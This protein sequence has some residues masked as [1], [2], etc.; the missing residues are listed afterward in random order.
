VTDTEVARL[1]RRVERERAAR[2]E[3]EAIA[4]RSTRELWDRQQELVLLEA[5]AGAANAADS[6][7]DALRLVLAMV[8]KHLRW[9]IGQAWV[10]EKEQG[11]LRLAPVSHAV[12]ESKYQPFLAASA[13]AEFRPGE[14][15]PGR[16]LANSEPLLLPDV[17]T[18]NNF[19]R[20][21][22]ALETG[23][24]GAVAFPV[25]L[26]D[27]TVAVL[28][29][30][31]DTVID[32]MPALLR[33]L[34]HVGVQLAR[35]FERAETSERL[36]HDAL[37]D[38]LT[39]LPNRALFA[40]R[41]TQAIAASRRA[42]GSA[43][44]ALMDLDR[45]KEVNDTLGHLQGDQL[46][47]EVGT[48]LAHVL[49]AQDTIA[50]L[51]GDEFGIVLSDV[52]D[53]ADVLSVAD[54]VRS[55]LLPPV[56]LEG[57]MVQVDASVGL[58]LYPEHGDEVETLLRRADIA[59]YE[60]KRHHFG[61]Q[62][63]RSDLDPHSTERLGMAAALRQAIDS[64][65]LTLHYQP[66]VAIRGASVVTGV[67]ALLRW[68]QPDRGPVPP[69]EFIPLAERTGLIRPLTSFVLEEAIAQASRWCDEGLTIPV[70]VNI[71]ARNLLDPNFPDEVTHLLAEAGLSPTLL[72]L[73]ITESSM[74]EDPDV[75]TAVLTRLGDLGVT[76]AIDDFG[77]G[78]SSM[79]QLK[80]LPVSVLKID[81]GFV[82]A[83]VSDSRD[84][85]IVG[86]TIQLGHDL[87][88]NIVAEG[89]ED[90]ATL[91]QLVALGCDTVQGFLIQRPGRA[92]DLTEWLHQHAGRPVTPLRE[93]PPQQH[94]DSDE[95]LLAG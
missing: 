1:Q 18:A 26:R 54:R 95:A 28:E 93:V 79:A 58:A 33:L 66:Q 40:D 3:A 43:A 8:C 73:E 62:L 24:R 64:R 80:Q 2:L 89:V 12:D 29:F 46:L 25:I 30:F 35:V 45:F 9:P 53:E 41:A 52:G 42:G 90:N 63:Y 74:L 77:T 59:M 82:S 87:G 20:V 27:R 71:T 88:L 19:P 23:L 83:L 39:G 85:F 44:V 10:I 65:S 38:T 86:S 67:E 22:V 14:G 92:E 51:G 81:R 17:T 5:V 56:E 91:Q 78:Y 61:C 7:D 32:S 57:I 31:T 34:N 6:T 55:A 50:R 37:H 11:V 68:N 72:E 4:E 16:V 60:A 84:A 94:Q 70:A 49:R 48:R 69:A 47:V 13:A 21:A 75:T 36:R 15:L 76:I